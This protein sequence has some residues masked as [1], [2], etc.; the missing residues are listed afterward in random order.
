MA[1][2]IRPI[3]AEIGV[4]DESQRIPLGGAEK[5]D[6]KTQSA[7]DR[8][9]AHEPDA[10]G[11]KLPVLGRDIPDGEREIRE[12]GRSRSQCSR[13]DAFVDGADSSLMRSRYGVSARTTVAPSAAIALAAILSGGTCTVDISLNPSART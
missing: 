9:I 8:S 10:G 3:A 6:P 5:Q 2:Q 4:F 1:A 11:A 12:P 7:F 13:S